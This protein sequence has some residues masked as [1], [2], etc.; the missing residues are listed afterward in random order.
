MSETNALMQNMAIF[1]AVSAAAIDFVVDHAESKQFVANQ[2]LFVEGDLSS[3]MY[4]LTEGRV[5]IF[6]DW[7]GKRFQL[8]E[9]GRGECVGEMSLLACSPRSASVMALENVQAIEI[10]NNLLADLY[11]TFPEQYTIFIM[12][13]AREICRRLEKTD[14]RLFAL[15]RSNLSQI[16][17][18][19]SHQTRSEVLI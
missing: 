4:V 13:M 1:G 5:A 3:S 14:R 16:G 10:S 2:Y 8:R 9:L 19:Q 7:E 18:S 11:L 12:N 6:R 17:R 15:D